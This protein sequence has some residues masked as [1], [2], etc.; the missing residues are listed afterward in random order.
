MSRPVLVSA[1]YLVRL[2]GGVCC[3]LFVLRDREEGIMIVLLV[4]FISDICGCWWVKV[5]V[6]EV[7]ATLRDNDSGLCTYSVEDGGS[8]GDGGGF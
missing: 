4:G 3:D 8:S 5:M 7:L 2:R 1:D 6:C